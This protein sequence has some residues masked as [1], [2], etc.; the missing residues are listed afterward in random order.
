MGAAGH[1]GIDDE[2]RREVMR[3]AE[4]LRF[5]EAQLTWD[6]AMAEILA[7]AH[8][9]NP[10]GLVVG[11][12]GRG[13]AEFGHGIPH[14]LADLGIDAVQVLLPWSAEAACA[15]LPAGI[16]DAVFV[17]D[18]TREDP[19]APRPLLGVMIEAADDGVRVSEVVAGSVAERSG[20]AVGDVIRRAA[21]FAIGTVAELIEII[22][23]QAPGTWLPLDVMRDGEAVEVIARFP[24]RFE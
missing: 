14:Q 20:L 7:Q 11:I 16:A 12:V 18:E 23:R 17:V 21:G 5:V 9:R 4:F 8:R 19:P 10:D 6:R 2:A 3:S 15:E 24:Q 1:G 22:R 13:H